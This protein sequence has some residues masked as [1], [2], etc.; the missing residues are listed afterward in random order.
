MKQK[1]FFSIV[2]FSLMAFSAFAQTTLKVGYADIDYILGN[3]PE[4][5]KAQ[6]DLDIVKDRLIKTRDSLVIDYNTKLKEYKENAETLVPATK[7]E[8]EIKLTQIERGIQRFEADIQTA[9]NIKKDEL[10]KPIYNRIGVLITTVA[11]Q[12]RYTHI[13][14]S[15][16]DG[17]SVLL[18]AE[19]K[20]DIS[21]LVIAEAKK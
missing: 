10:L 15:Q 14:N 18:Y 13:I 12:N 17:N 6:A 3:M 11:K 16:I 5:I 9:I 19:E 1:T 21:D 2:L 7:K 8:T 4:T 20:T